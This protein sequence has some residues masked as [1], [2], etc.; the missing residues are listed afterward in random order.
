MHKFLPVVAA[1]VLVTLVQAAHAGEVTGKVEHID[2][3]RD[4][5][6]VGP[7]LLK[8]SEMNSQGVKLNELTEG[9]Q[10]KVIYDDE[11]SE[12]GKNIVVDMQRVEK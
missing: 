3:A 9:Q 5:F 4:T 11:T 1:A 7:K 6:I 12:D 8:W 2:P 10:V